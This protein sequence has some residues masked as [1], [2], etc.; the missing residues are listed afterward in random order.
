[1]KDTLGWFLMFTLLAMPV[2]GVF[3]AILTDNDWWWLLCLPILLFL[4]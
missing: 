2:V 4:S 1:V 3:L